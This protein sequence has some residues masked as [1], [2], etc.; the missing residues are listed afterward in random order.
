MIRRRM[1]NPARL[2]EPDDGPL[3]TPPEWTMDS[4]CAPIGGADWDSWEVEEQIAWCQSCPVIESCREYGIEQL[5]VA[6]KSGTV[7]YG[8]LAPGQIVKA[9]RARRGE[10]VA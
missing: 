8:G 1:A 4:R 9:A 6:D 3:I 5:R 2:M 7:V 10:E